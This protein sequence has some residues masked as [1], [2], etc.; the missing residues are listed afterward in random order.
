VFL[1]EY[2]ESAVNIR[3]QYCFSMNDGPGGLVIRSDLLLA[4]GKRFNENGISIPFPQRDVTM[5][6]GGDS[7]AALAGLAGRGALEDHGDGLAPIQDRND[8]RLEPP[9][10]S[11]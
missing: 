11:A 2:A 4:I 9:D 5:H 7:R 10:G 6:L 3:L 8:A 1:W